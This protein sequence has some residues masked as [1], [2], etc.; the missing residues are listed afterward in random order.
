MKSAVKNDLQR[1]FLAGVRRVDPETLIAGTLS[2]KGSFLQITAE[3]RER[4]I[5]LDTFDQVLVMGAG[6]ATARMARALEAVL[7]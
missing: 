2:R 3:E 4:V 7:G 6:K 5:D 1:I